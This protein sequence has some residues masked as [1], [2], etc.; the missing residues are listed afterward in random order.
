MENILVLLR[1][2]KTVSSKILV[3]VTNGSALGY[4]RLIIYPNGYPFEQVIKP[5]K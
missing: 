1:R 2:V 3:S 4:R 5:K